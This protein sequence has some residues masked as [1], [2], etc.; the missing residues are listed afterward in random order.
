MW[1]SS[2]FVKGAAQL[3]YL[4]TSHN[5]E[6][7]GE[8]SLNEDMSTS[9]WPSACLWRIVLLFI[10]VFVTTTGTRTEVVGCWRSFLDLAAQGLHLLHLPVCVRSQPNFRPSHQT[11]PLFLYLKYEILNSDSCPYQ[12]LPPLPLACQ[13]QVPVHR[14]GAQRTHHPH[15]N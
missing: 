4:S 9:G 14:P 5:P 7:S 2:L 11:A 3:V 15:N 8:E 10:R 12:R 13:L 1:V 6:S